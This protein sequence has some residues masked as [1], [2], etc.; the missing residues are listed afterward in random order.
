MLGGTW[1]ASSNLEKYQLNLSIFF[2][3]PD[4]SDF[5]LSS[6]LLFIESQNDRM[7]WLGRDIKGHWFQVH[8]MGRLF[9]GFWSF[10]ALWDSF[11][12][13][14]YLSWR[15]TSRTAVHVPNRQWSS[16]HPPPAY[17]PFPRCRDCWVMFT[18]WSTIILSSFLQNCYSTVG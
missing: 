10:L 17:L 13:S 1:R 6:N 16:L 12:F 15:L 2:S 9:L 4:N 3:R 14:T 7:A 11:L 8:A 5:C 18:R